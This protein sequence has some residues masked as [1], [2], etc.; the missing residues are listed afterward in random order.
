MAD[1]TTDIINAALLRLGEK[2]IDDI[3]DPNDRDARIMAILYSGTKNEVLSVFP[4]NCAITRA[5]LTADEDVDNLT[6]YTYAYELPDDVIRILDIDGD[7]TIAYRI[8]GNYIFT[9]H[10][11]ATTPGQAVIRYIQNLEDVS[12]WDEILEE[13]MVARLAEKAC[14]RISSN[15][16]LT[17]YLQK[18]YITL[19][20]IAQQGAAQEDKE[21]I[22]AILAQLNNSKLADILMAKNNYAAG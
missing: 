1:S 10:A 17:A 20:T 18:E 5:R 14:M 16:N 13:T 8:E 9:G 15:I 7:N 11:G 21:D 2:A 22:T 3:N 6:E 19:L 4:W 12:L